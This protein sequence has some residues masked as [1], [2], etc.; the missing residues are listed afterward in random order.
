MQNQ[1]SLTRLFIPYLPEENDDDIPLTEGMKFQS[2]HDDVEDLQPIEETQDDEL[3]SSMFEKYFKDYY[4]GSYVD[5]K[6]VIKFRPM[7]ARAS[8]YRLTLMGMNTL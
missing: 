8:E 3:S 7:R 1:Q 6:R 2:P 5:G 4:S